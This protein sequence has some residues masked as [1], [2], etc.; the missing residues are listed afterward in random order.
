MLFVL[1]SGVALGYIAEDLGA[2]VAA[3][4]EEVLSDIKA[5]LNPDS[6]ISRTRGEHIY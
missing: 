2:G 5:G 3:A 1:G 6:H 4:G